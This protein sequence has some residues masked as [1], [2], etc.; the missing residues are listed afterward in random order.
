VAQRLRFGRAEMA[1]VL[2]KPK[3]IVFDLGEDEFVS[4]KTFAHFASA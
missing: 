2:E 3:L 4:N 1:V